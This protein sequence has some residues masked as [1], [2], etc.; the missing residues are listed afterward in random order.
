V[1]REFRVRVEVAEP[2]ELVE[3]TYDRVFVLGRVRDADS[4]R[5]ELVIQTDE[6]STLGGRP[7]TTIVAVPRYV[8]D[9]FDQLPDADVIVNA[10]AETAADDIHFAVSSWLSDRHPDQTNPLTFEYRYPSKSTFHEGRSR[11]MVLLAR[12]VDST[13][14]ATGH[15]VGDSGGCGTPGGR[16]EIR[17]HRQPR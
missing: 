9:S 7:I 14:L 2:F 5:D 15:P 12:A 10:R 17:Q 4:S 1:T 16:L 8:G 6:G 13:D 3:H 11:L